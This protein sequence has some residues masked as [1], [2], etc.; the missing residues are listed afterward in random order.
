[1]IVTSRQVVRT[2]CILGACAPLCVAFGCG[3]QT[4]S[5]GEWKPAATLRFEA[6]EGELDG[7]FV[8]SDAT[9][10]GDAFIQ[11]ETDEAAEDEPGPARARY[12]FSLP[13]SLAMTFW[14]E[15]VHPDVNTNRLWVKVDD[16]AWYKWRIAVGDVWY[17]DDFHGN[18]DCGRALVRVG[19]G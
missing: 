14:G 18:T 11:P 16:G 9:A 13:Y 19:R 15:S 7:F 4:T 6:E 10:G 3:R 17:W 5:I 1:M 12:A 8:Q 2:A